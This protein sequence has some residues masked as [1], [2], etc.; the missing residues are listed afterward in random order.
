MAINVKNVPLI[1]KV[2]LNRMEFKNALLVKKGYYLLMEHVKK[3][4]Q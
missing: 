3:V 2:A 1:V 4:A